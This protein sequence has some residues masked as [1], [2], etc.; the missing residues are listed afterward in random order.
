MLTKQWEGGS[1]KCGRYWADGQYGPFRLRCL[2][3]EG[4]EEEEDPGGGSFFG[5][6][7]DRRSLSVDDGHNHTIR[8]VFELSH[9]GCPDEKARTVTQLQYLG[10]PDMDVPASPKSLLKLMWDVNKLA[11]ASRDEKGAKPILLHCSAGVGRTGAF[12]MIDA[13][14]DGIRNE[15][16]ARILREKAR[17]SSTS[18]VS[19]I[20]NIR[21]DVCTPHQG[22]LQRVLSENAMDVDAKSSVFVPP[23]SAPPKSP[24]P[25]STVGSQ[26]IHFHRERLTPVPPFQ[27][28]NPVGT[29]EGQEVSESNRGQVVRLSMAGNDA[30]DIHIP[31]VPSSAS[32]SAQ[33]QT[34]KPNAYRSLEPSDSGSGGSGIRSPVLVPN[35]THLQMQHQELLHRRIQHHQ[36]Q[37]LESESNHRHEREQKYFQTLSHHSKPVMNDFTIADADSMFENETN[38]DFAMD[39]EAV[40]RPETVIRVKAKG[41]GGSGSGSGSTNISGERRNSGSGSSSG[42]GSGSDGHLT[43]PLRKAFANMSS[44]DD[45]SG[46]MEKFD[47]MRPRWSKGS[48]NENGSGSGEVS[49]GSSSDVSGKVSSDSVGSGSGSSL[50]LGAFS[51]LG[52]DSPVP[53]PSH[54]REGLNYQPASAGAVVTIPEGRPLPPQSQWPTNISMQKPSLL[55]PKPL[56]LQPAVPNLFKGMESN[57]RHSRPT[58]QLPARHRYGGSKR[59]SSVQSTT[60]TSPSVPSSSLESNLQSSATD[61]FETPPSGSSLQPSRSPSSKPSFD[62]RQ[63]ENDGGNETR[64]GM[65]QGREHGHSVGFGSDSGLESGKG[66]LTVHHDVESDWDSPRKAYDFASPRALHSKDSPPLLSSFEDPIQQVLEDMREQRMSLCQSLRQYVF[67][68]NAIV[69]GAIDVVDQERLRAD[70]RAEEMFNVME[71]SPPLDKVLTKRPSIDLSGAAVR[72]MDQAELEFAVGGDGSVESGGS[73]EFSGGADGNACGGKRGASPTELTKKDM[74]GEVALAKR[75]SVKRGKSTSPGNI[76]ASSPSSL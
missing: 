16:R 69:E 59:S 19:D 4:S 10:W 21:A 45:E 7:S 51:K 3:R 38:P 65:M 61:S 72:D 46:G 1:I 27:T 63:N 41:S 52:V 55:A 67:V 34:P 75:P 42:S 62:D 73:G 50:G 44:A 56:R 15:V 49:A 9:T 32:P 66:R 58:A 22:Q 25:P 64:K 36:Q 31:L 14:L 48:G 54:K 70:A 6:K 23:A 76:S 28:S 20:A 37:Q 18:T 47:M 40:P 43:R 33:L 60:S 2:H 53:S 26:S 71:T 29:R 24:T 57:S 35:Q 30:P 39:I 11:E 68:H 17:S 5:V 12:I 13:V 74:K 8:R